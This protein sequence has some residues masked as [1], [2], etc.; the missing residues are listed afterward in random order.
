M[1]KVAL[2]GLVALAGCASS[3]EIRY[4]ADVHVARANIKASQGDTVGAQKE[5]DKAHD[6]YLKAERRAQREMYGWI[7]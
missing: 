5:M 1:W 7:M 4:N 6:Q 2:V 3:E